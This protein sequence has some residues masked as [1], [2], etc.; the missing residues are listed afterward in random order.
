MNKV[1]SKFK[2]LLP[3]FK[4]PL[5]KFKILSRRLPLMV[6]PMLVGSS[7]TSPSTTPTQATPSNASP[8]FYLGGI[9]VNEE[10][11][12]AWFDAL[13]QEEMN[14][15]QVTAYARQGDWDSDNLFWDEESPWVLAEIRGAKARGLQVVFIA[16]VALDHA[17]P[18]NAFLWHGMIWPQSDD[19][20]AAWFERYRR[21]VVMWA[22][23]AERE[24]VD[25]FI[26]GSEMNSLASTLPVAEIPA[27]EEYYLNPEK[28]AER[29]KQ[30]LAHVDLIENRALYLHERETFPT[31]EA[32]LE[33]RIN[34]EREW[35]ARRVQPD[36]NALAALN[37]RRQLLAEHWTRVIAAVRAVYRGK[38][39]YAANF[40]QYQEVGFWSQLDFM[41][42]NA[43]F[44]LRD[45]ILPPDQLDQ[46]YPLLLAGWRGVLADI[47]KF[48]VAQGLTLPV[49]FTEMGFTYRAESTLE[50]WSDVGFSVIRTPVIRTPVS[51][52]PVSGSPQDP[53]KRDDLT[54]DTV[55]EQVIVWRDQPERPTERALAVRAL[56][57]AHRELPTPFLRGILYWKLSSHEYHKKNESFMVK[58][59][60]PS[61]DPILPELRRFLHDSTK[62]S[63]G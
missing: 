58:I 60:G 10:S 59:G 27:L 57:A 53:Q 61:D 23:I 48:R 19:L 3:K 51:R 62:A 50:P 13:A 32:Y 2:M 28:Q 39:G 34:T 47:H 8:D 35:A 56:H 55:H 4:M 11:H 15:V 26:V 52:T 54:A 18:R 5:S 37:A 31:V 36:K 16:R 20:L 1:L 40:D 33:A 63:G 17:F 9:Q 29:Q 7:C 25:I 21:F 12:A 6:L 49:I 30:V 22:E 42:I 44:K 41:G 24:G 14:T 45:R 46:L 43:Y 38:I